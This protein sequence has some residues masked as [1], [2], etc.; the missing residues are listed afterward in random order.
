MDG[1]LTTGAVF[2]IRPGEAE[3]SYEHLRPTGLLAE[4]RSAQIPE[5]GRGEGTLFGRSLPRNTK[6]VFQA[7]NEPSVGWQSRPAHR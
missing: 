4:S 7:S 1:V 2:E 5:R 6:C 3:R